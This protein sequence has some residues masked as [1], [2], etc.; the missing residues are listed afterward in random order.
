MFNASSRKNGQI[1]AKQ[2][3]VECMTLDHVQDLSSE[4]EG[5]DE[6]DIE[7]DECIRGLASIMSKRNPIRSSR[8]RDLYVGRGRGR[9]IYNGIKLF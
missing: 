1:D 9:H 5:M 4:D 8:G 2:K 7:L 3:D 6:D